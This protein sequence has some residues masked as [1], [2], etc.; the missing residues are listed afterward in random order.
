MRVTR[1]S[2]LGS[3]VL[4]LAPGAARASYWLQGT[5]ENRQEEALREVLAQAAASRPSEAAAALSRVTAD[6][7][8]TKASGLAQLAAGLILARAEQHRDAAARLQHPDI[9]KTSLLDVALFQLGRAREEL[10]DPA[11]AAEAYTQAAA[12]EPKSPLVCRALLSAGETYRQ[13]GRPDRAVAVLASA[14]DRCPGQEGQVLLGLGMAHETGRD[15]AAAART[16]DRL[17]REFPGA[18][19]A[20]EAATRLG[21]L[22]PHAPRVSADERNTRDLKRAQALAD[23]GR[24]G[25]AVKLLRAV[26]ARGAAGVDPSRVRLLLGRELAKGS[27][28][29]AREALTVL[30]AVDASSSSGAEAAYLLARLKT[31]PARRPDAF[32]AV[33][34]RFPGSP[35]AEEALVAL[36]NLHG[37]DA[38]EG[39]ALPYWERIARDFPDGRHAD[40][41]TWKV[42]WADYRSRRFD[43]A[44]E[45]L[46]AAVRARPASPSAAT[47]LYWAGRSRQEAGAAARARELFEETIA[48]FK[49]TYYGLMARRAMATLGATPASAHAALMAPAPSSAAAEVPAPHLQ[50][51]RELLLADLLDQALDELRAVPASPKVQATIAWIHWRQGRLRSAIT[52]MKR[53][54]PEHASAAGD[55][56]PE[57]VWSILFPLQYVD[58]LTRRAIEAGLDP[59][60]VAAV[61]CQESTF[62]SGAVSG[63]GARGLMQVMPAT[64]RSLARAL[65]VRYQKGALNDPAVSL[66]FGTHYLAELMRR[67]GGR[68]DRALAAYNAGPGRV[69]KWTAGNR[70]MPLDEFVETIPFSETRLYVMIILNNLEH[71]R[72]IHALGAAPAPSQAA[73]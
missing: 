45:R 39:D 36:A 67:F 20:G 8:G 12:V 61:I 59:A 71:Y 47:W 53:A 16:Y 64:G 10:R 43:A 22:G 2:A 62:D 4:L 23:A 27:G 52:A 37:K 57:T 55:R 50:R 1:L 19:G 42:A 70:D 58:T 28:P 24:S 6:H 21:T 14:T 68:V 49:H 11:G 38:R 44:A 9:Q 30:S 32:A 66:R 26:L 72:S 17:L 60:L 51:L 73:P 31:P 34:A 7:P 29:R 18:A 15:L 40:R 69:V 25:D 48:R 46:E 35:W 13:A 33:V 63:V 54:Y 3:V 41:A 5:P 56:L 65:K